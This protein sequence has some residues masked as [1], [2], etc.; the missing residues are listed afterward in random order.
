MSQKVRSAVI[1]LVLANL[2]AS[3]AYALPPVGGQSFH[4]RGGVLD[5]AWE[6]FA[7]LLAPAAKETG[8]SVVWDKA[9]SSMDPNGDPQAV[10]PVS[11]E[12]STMGSSGL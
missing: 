8:V 4:Q 6:W 2:V 9:G 5:A 10:I 1:V 7:A 12:D 11:G 3:A